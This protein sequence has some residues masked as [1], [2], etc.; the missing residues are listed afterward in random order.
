MHMSTYT[1][2]ATRHAAPLRV[3]RAVANMPVY[4]GPLNAPSEATLAKRAQEA[5]DMA[6]GTC[7]ECYMLLTPTGCPNGC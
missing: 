5:R 3:G 4:R 6:R 2:F 7:P 1:E